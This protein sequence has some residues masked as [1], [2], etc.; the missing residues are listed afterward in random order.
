MSLVVVAYLLIAAWMI[1]VAQGAIVGDEDL[2]QEHKFRQDA[3]AIITGVLWPVL[4]LTMIIN[5]IRRLWRQGDELGSDD[6]RGG[7]EDPPREGT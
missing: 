3:L 5:F 1:H 2:C 6:S 7:E 4:F